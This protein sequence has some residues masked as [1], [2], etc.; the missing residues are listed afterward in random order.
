MFQTKVWLYTL[1]FGFYV[2]FL[3]KW[4]YNHPP[5]VDARF[6]VYVGLH[7]KYILKPKPI[8]KQQK[9]SNWTTLHLVGGGGGQIALQCHVDCGVKVKAV[10]CVRGGGTNSGGIEPST[11]I[12]NLQHLSSCTSATRWFS[13]RGLSEK[14]A[15]ALLWDNWYFGPSWA[16]QRMKV[17]ADVW[18]GRVGE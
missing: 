7:A 16:C 3:W 12:E 4:Q 18:C 1:T 5:H 10:F 11:A 15:P 17:C 13:W 2:H 8:C 14:S 9:K 6:T